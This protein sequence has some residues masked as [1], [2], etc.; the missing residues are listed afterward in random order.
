MSPSDL[1]SCQ[2]KNH[3]APAN[4]CFGIFRP[5]TSDEES[6]GENLSSPS[7]SISYLF[8]DILFRL[9]P[10]LRWLISRRI[11]R[12]FRNLGITE[13]SNMN[14]RHSLLGI[15]RSFLCSNFLIAICATF[16]GSWIDRRVI[17]SAWLF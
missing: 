2:R 15:I 6:A 3:V 16:S 10:G 11:I 9:Y 7:P 13:F 14:V 5:G 1:S 12:Y 17:Q 4:R 8:F